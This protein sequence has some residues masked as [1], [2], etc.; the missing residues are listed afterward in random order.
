M[1]IKIR[2]YT[3]RAFVGRRKVREIILAGQSWKGV[4]MRTHVMML[5]SMADR[6]AVGV[7]YAGKVNFRLPPARY[8]EWVRS[9]GRM[10]YFPFRIPGEIKPTK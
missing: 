9:L 2:P 10:P 8:M 1:Q 7:P 4:L 3:I 6:I 5:A